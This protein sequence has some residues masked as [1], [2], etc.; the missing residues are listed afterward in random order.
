[1]PLVNQKLNGNLTVD[2]TITQGGNAV[3][4]QLVSGTNIK[5]INGSSVLGSGDLVVGGGGGIHALI[6]PVSGSGITFAINAVNFS[7]TGTMAANTLTTIPFIPATTFTIDQIAFEVTTSV[8]SS[9]ATVSIYSNSNMKPTNRLYL[10][11]I[12]ST[13]TNGLKTISTSFTFNAGTIYWIGFNS[14]SSTTNF[15]NISSSWTYNF[16]MQ[17]TTGGTFGQNSWDSSTVVPG[18]EPNPLTFHVAGFRSFPLVV[19]RTV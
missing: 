5:T 14:S 19:F 10:S 12:I 13:D 1:M 4:Q 6:P 2:G 11:P 16:R 9:T 8:A 17:N 15:R 3:Q 7:S 18:G